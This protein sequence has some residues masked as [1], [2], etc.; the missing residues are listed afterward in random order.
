MT[1][2]LEKARAGYRSRL[3]QNQIVYLAEGPNPYVPEEGLLV[4][5]KA[6]VIAACEE[7]YRYAVIRRW[8]D[9]RTTPGRSGLDTSKSPR[10]LFTEGEVIRA[11]HRCA[12]LGI[13]D[14][15]VDCLTEDPAINPRL[16]IALARTTLWRMADDLPRACDPEY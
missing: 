3:S 2:R 10:E 14:F 13:P 4:A 7:G 6:T 5:K 8:N 11:I 9:V 12:D 15:A 16:A 1:D